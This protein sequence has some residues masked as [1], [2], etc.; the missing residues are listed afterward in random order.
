MQNIQKSDNVDY[1]VTF[2]KIDGGYEVWHPDFG[3]TLSVWEKTLDKA[4]TELYGMRKR[5][6]GYLYNDG[7]PIPEPSDIDKIYDK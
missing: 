6:I 4:L 7:K 3:L 1:P 2:R 5:Y